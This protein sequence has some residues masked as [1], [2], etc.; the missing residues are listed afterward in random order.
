MAHNYY[1][2]VS[3][4]S[5]T[6][7]LSSYEWMNKCSIYPNVWT[8]PMQCCI[9]LTALAHA[10]STFC[11]SQRQ[12]PFSLPQL[13]VRY[14]CNHVSTSADNADCSSLMRKTFAV[15]I[16]IIIVGVTV[17]SIAGL[18]IQEVLLV[19]PTMYSTQHFNRFL[20]SLPHTKITV[21]ARSEVWN[22]FARSNAVVVGSNPTKGMDVCLRL[23]CVWCCP[24]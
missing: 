14:W 2:E 8:C 6:S 11:S 16:Y 4:V 24:V 19:F 21:A 15:E 5:L 10:V 7:W 9:I 23:F 13:F 22:L 17:C 12:P 18:L 3:R 1:C 20:S